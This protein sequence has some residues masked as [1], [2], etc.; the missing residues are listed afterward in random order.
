M[1]PGHLPLELAGEQFTRLGP[2]R[3]T[4]YRHRCYRLSGTFAPTKRRQHTP[5]GR[6]SVPVFKS[7]SPE[8]AEAARVAKA[9]GQM[10]RAIGRAKRA[11][12]AGPAGQAR[13]AKEAGQRY[14]QIEMPVV[15]TTRTIGSMLFGDVTTRDRRGTGQGALLTVIEE[16]GWELVQAGFVFHETGQVSRDKFL[17][18]G[19]S[20]RTTGQT[21]GVYL[22]R[23]T[24]EPART[25]Q[26]W[27][28]AVTGAFQ[29]QSTA[30]RRELAAG[31]AASAAEDRQDEILE[32]WEGEDID[33]ATLD[34]IT[35]RALKK[36]GRI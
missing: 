11:F 31:S 25:D 16:E 30:P 10:L 28:E 6:R 26:P 35:R 27:V 9:E 32:A 7:K 33:P 5:P 14:Y 22:F 8:A 24:M 21:F 13:I 36:A 1:L 17:S 15:E 34:P 4:V 18:T 3:E 29:R 20:I 19:Q 2:L 12:L 23:A